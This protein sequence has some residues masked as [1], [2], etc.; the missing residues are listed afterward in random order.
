MK[1]K[2][3]VA[4]CCGVAAGTALMFCVYFVA[5]YPGYQK[6]KARKWG[7]DAGVQQGYE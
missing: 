2:D 7:Q 4:F 6:A 3:K 1:R 5:M